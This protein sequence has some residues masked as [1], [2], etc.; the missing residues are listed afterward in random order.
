MSV[1]TAGHL[2]VRCAVIGLLLI[3][4]AGQ[5][6]E[7][8]RDRLGQITFPNSGAP[9]AQA[10]F[11]RGVALLHSYE[12]IDARTAFAAARTADPSF[13]LAWWFEAMTFSQFDWG[14]EDLPAAQATLRQLAPT[15]QERLQK[16]GSTSERQFGAAIET[17]LTGGAPLTRA[18]RF[19]AD[20]RTWSDS[21]S[22]HLEALAFSARAALY[23]LRYAPPSDR[24]QRAEEAM[25]LANQVIKADPAH[26][27]GLHYLVHASDSPRL[28]ARGLDAARRYDKIAPDADHALHMPSHIFLQLGMWSEVASANERAWAASRAW[29]IQEKRGVVDMGW[30][31]LQWLQ[32]AYL[33]Q[34]RYRAARALLDSARAILDSASLATMRGYPDATHARET[35]AF[36][37]GAETGDWITALRDLG[38]KTFALDSLGY[39]SQRE[40]Q[41]A[42]SAAYHSAVAHL[43]ARSDTARG[44]QIIDVLR[45]A[46]TQLEESTPLYMTIGEMVAQLTALTLSTNGSLEAGIATLRAAIPREGALPTAPLGPPTMLPSLEVLA[47]LLLDAGRAAEAR[48]LLQRALAERANRASA[49][50][51]LATAEALLGDPS[52]AAGRYRQ[53]DVNWSEADTELRLALDRARRAIRAKR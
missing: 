48:P 13:A 37:Y 8:Q 15:R 30:H 43:L 14:I 1:R 24:E 53:L 27:G 47:Q 26:P 16:A 3:T 36:Q 17:F 25:G 32:Y 11:L 23:V 28:A 21:T 33:Q 5:R 10:P 9:N 42:V 44:E 22:E 7:A 51:A 31:S 52:A 12:Y 34:G 4:A 38:S 2:I 18:L 46:R 49:I 19:A 35:L 50:R 45:R 41:Q 29:A 39:I 40:R 6:L 20:L